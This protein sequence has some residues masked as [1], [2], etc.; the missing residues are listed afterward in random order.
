MAIR[1]ICLKAGLRERLRIRSNRRGPP[2]VTLGKA[3]RIHKQLYKKIPRF[4]CIEGCTDCC[5]P[6]P[7]STYELQQARLSAPPPD[8]ADKTCD[9]AKGGRCA[10]HEHRPL[11]CRLFGTVDD[12]RCPHGRGPLKRLSTETGHDI[13][14]RYKLA[15]KMD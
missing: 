14:R 15:N 3:A 4:E 11:M 10:I 7:W 13:V 8:N 9:F 6:V 2:S 1:L 5:G 12:L